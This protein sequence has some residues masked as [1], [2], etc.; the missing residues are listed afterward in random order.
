M[1]MTIAIATQRIP[2]TDAKH[3]RLRIE[4]WTSGHTAPNSI[5]GA[6][7][8]RPWTFAPISVMIL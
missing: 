6:R 5:L 4:T 1:T 3:H 2:E 8:I 7:G